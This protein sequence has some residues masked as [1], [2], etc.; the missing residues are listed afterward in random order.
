MNYF[1]NV[2]L[3]YLSIIKVALSFPF[4]LFPKQY[5]TNNYTYIR[6]VASH[7]GICIEFENKNNPTSVFLLSNCLQKL[8]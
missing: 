2:S 5:L 3:A 4:N 8:R 6:I 1:T 7:E